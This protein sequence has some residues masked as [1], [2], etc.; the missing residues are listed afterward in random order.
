MRSTHVLSNLSATSVP[1][2]K[3]DMQIDGPMATFMLSGLAPK[4]SMAVRVF[5]VMPFAAPRHPACAM[6]IIPARESENATGT[7]SAVLTPMIIPRT[8]VTM[9]SVLS[10]D[11]LCHGT[12]VITD[13]SFECT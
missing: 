10:K 9:A 13:T 7:Q 11:S 12:D 5:S 3:H 6:P 2:S 4:S 1:T 8:L